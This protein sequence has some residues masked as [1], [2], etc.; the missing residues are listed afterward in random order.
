MR[1][2]I[3]RIIFSL[4]AIGFVVSAIGLL[5]YANGY[6]FN[7]ESWWFDKTGVVA[8]DSVPTNA[9]ISLGTATTGSFWQRSVSQGKPYKT[10]ARVTYVLPGQYHV[11]LS[12]EGFW[13]FSRDIDVQAGVTSF[14]SNSVL[15]KKDSVR[16]VLAVESIRSVHVIGKSSY[17]VQTPNDLF[18]V[19]RK[20][21]KTEKLYHSQQE[22]ST[23][24]VAPSGLFSLFK[25]G[26][27]WL[28]LDFNKSDQSVSLLKV[29]KGESLIFGDRDTVYGCGENGISAY[30]NLSRVSLKKET[31][32]LG[33]EVVDMI[34][35]SLVSE[36]NS[37]SLRA[38]PLN[39]LK[40]EEQ[41]IAYLPSGKASFGESSFPY[42]VINTNQDKTY[43]YNIQD[44]QHHLIDLD[45][46]NEAVKY[47]MS[48][49]IANNSVEI[50]TYH[51]N[52][53][54]LSKELITREGSAISNVL[55][56]G[57]IPYVFFV[58]D[59]RE[60]V[61]LEQTTFNPNRY[62]LATLD[63]ISM[64]RVLPDN[65]TLLIAGTQQGV[66]G[67]FEISVLE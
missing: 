51:V 61:A 25:T 5:L 4:F 52:G 58:R 23:L 35:Y 47:D 65:K 11:V 12:K 55:V 3:R 19:D 42:M 41:V 20:S 36:K 30:P 62:T 63:H 56:I 26:D 10:P 64:V 21:G 45:G 24:L 14:F 2:W 49:L 13:D 31:S 29:E 7:I 33:C 37:V 16:Q 67:I 46:M 34:L 8:I 15:L 9:T 17:L 40:G 44:S 54:D 38:L 28:R 59:G 66:E 53:S 32:I 57:M 60:L 18:F 27:L 39:Q 1:L 50:N 48:T 43:L 22:I 6:R